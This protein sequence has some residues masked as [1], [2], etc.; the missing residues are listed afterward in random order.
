MSDNTLIN[1]LWNVFYKF[2]NFRYFEPDF[3]NLKVKTKKEFEELNGGTCWDFI[4]PMSEEL[5]RKDIVHHC[6]FSYIYK[7]NVLFAT[8]VYIIVRDLPFKYWLECAWQK[9]KGLFLV[10]SYKDV[11]RHLKESYETDD[12]HTVVYDPKCV[13]GKTANQLFEYLE[14]DGIKL[15]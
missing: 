15:P 8:H 3:T 9:H 11:E 6:C 14:K 4:G 7:E 13:Y 12:V 2:N 5:D 1:S 10:H